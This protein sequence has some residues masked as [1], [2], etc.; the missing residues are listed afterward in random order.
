MAGSAVRPEL[1]GMTAL[2]LFTPCILALRNARQKQE[3]ENS[4]QTNLP[5]N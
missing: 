2:A 5:L 4:Y 3:K 1:R